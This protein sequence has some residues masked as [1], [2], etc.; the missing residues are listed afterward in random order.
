MTPPGEGDLHVIIRFDEL[1]LVVVHEGKAGDMAT[2]QAAIYQLTEAWP[3]VVRA[4]FQV[5]PAKDE[6]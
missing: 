4:T 5:I 6:P 3:D 2:Q 1:N